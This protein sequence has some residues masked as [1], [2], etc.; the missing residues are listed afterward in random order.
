[1]GFTEFKELW[2]ALNQWKVGQADLTVE[3]SSP[4]WFHV[5]LRVSVRVSNL[6]FLLYHRLLLCSSTLTDQALW[7]HMNYMLHSLPSVR[8]RMCSG[9]MSY[10]YVLQSGHLNHDSLRSGSERNR[11]ARTGAGMKVTSPSFPPQSTLISLGAWSQART[12]N[13]MAL[14]FFTFCFYFF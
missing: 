13:A 2:G 14:L 9:H 3:C 10:M 12:M 6:I 7:K 8:F 1:M 5:E 4:H 11:R